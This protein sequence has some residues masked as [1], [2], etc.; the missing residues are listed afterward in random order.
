METVLAHGHSQPWLE[1]GLPNPSAEQ[2]W[3]HFESPLHGGCVLTS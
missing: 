2:S 1:P 3:G